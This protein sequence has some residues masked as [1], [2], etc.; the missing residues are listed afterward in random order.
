[1]LAQIPVALEEIRQISWRARAIPK[2]IAENW[3]AIDKEFAMIQAITESIIETISGERGSLA[4]GLSRPKVMMNEFL[5]HGCGVLVLVSEADPK[6]RRFIWKEE[7]TGKEN[8]YC[9]DCDG[10]LISGE[11]P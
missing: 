11:M 1:M 6:K 8:S 7:K 4:E 10:K 9:F 3:P 2:A 5:C